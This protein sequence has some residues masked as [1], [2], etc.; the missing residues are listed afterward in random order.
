L[1]VGSG[2][3]EHALVWKIQ[4]SP[5]VSE[6]Y[7]APGNGGTALLAHNLSIKPTDFRALARAAEEHQVELIV[8]GPE[9]PLAAG[10]ADYMTGLGIPTF[11]PSKAA[12]QIEASKAFA[13]DLMQRHGIPCA[14]SAT[15]SSFEEARAY[16]ESRPAP[17][18]V[19]ADG[20]AAGKGVIMA[21]TREEALAALTQIMRESVFGPAGERVVIEERLT[22]TEVSLLALTDGEIVLPLV[23]A[24]DYKRV[25]DGDRGLNTGGMG[26]YSPPGFFGEELIQE[27]QRTIL[28]P[29]IRA[30][31][32]EGIQYKG[33]LYAGL[34]LTSDGP[35][36]LEFTARFGD[37]ETQAILPRLKSD[38]VEAMLSCINGTL[39]KIKLDW[40]GD[41]CV[42]VVL[43]SGGYPGSYDTGLPVSGLSD[44]D[45]EVAVFHAGTRL[46]EDGRTV[47]TAGG[48]VLTV[49]A[50]GPTMAEARN[51][52]YRNI[53][54]LRFQGCHYRRDI[55]EREV[56]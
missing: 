33:V 5:L 54:R 48:R 17:L 25:F 29:T 14:A 38:L 12:A 1:V 43:A 31:A 56:V 26:S 28:E 32:K 37:P 53:P 42:G 15:F 46:A 3:R 35:K 8:V 16:L 24:C 51:K 45:E 47:L 4:Q 18:V 50:C 41:A 23:P 44:L 2:A 39:H 49:V 36:V 55:A 21:Q 20:L 27:A 22:G 52:V 13:K 19:K 30:L 11:G 6:V 10:I 34:M 9:D 40:T 7:V